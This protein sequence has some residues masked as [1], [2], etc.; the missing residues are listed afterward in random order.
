MG[1]AGRT[2]SSVAAMT[3]AMTAALPG[4]R[5]WPSWVMKEV[6]SSSSLDTAA[7]MPGG[8]ADRGAQQRLQQQ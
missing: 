4:S 8:S 2:L 6:S 7:V 5:R 3:R 1:D